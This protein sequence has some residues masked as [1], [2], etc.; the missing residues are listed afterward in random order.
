[1]TGTLLT[2]LTDTGLDLIMISLGLKIARIAASVEL[3]PITDDLASVGLYSLTKRL[4]NLDSNIG[5]L[6]TVGF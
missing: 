4:I 5:T 1:M 6:G 2:L 3:I